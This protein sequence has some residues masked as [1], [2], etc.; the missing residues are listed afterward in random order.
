MRKP[1]KTNLISLITNIITF[2]VIYFVTDYFFF[3]KGTWRFDFWD[4]VVLPT[5]AAAVIWLIFEWK[6]WKKEE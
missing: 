3:E 4:T 2:I 1:T 6:P 5:L